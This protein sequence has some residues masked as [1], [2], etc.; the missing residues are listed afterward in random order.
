[1]NESRLEETYI[2]L[3]RYETNETVDVLVL[4]P[5]GSVTDEEFGDD[6]ITAADTGTKRI[7]YF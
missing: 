5:D 6:Y 3:F 1:M 4:P 2:E 7:W